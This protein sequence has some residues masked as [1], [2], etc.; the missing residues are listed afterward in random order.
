MDQICRCLVD[1]VTDA[2]IASIDR[3]KICD[4]ASTFHPEHKLC[5]V[6]CEPTKG[7]YNICFPVVFLLGEGVTDE[8]WVIR[9]PL[10]L[11]LAF[12]EEKMRGE[13]AT[14]KCAPPRIFFSL[15]HRVCKLTA[16]LDIL[17]QTPRS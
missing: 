14:M 8:K 6:F 12:P 3:S 11:R 1:D 2:F 15:L 10:T 13:I 5:R 17:H 9:I 4:L 16:H 7:S